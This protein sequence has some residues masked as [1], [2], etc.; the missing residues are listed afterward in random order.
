M[1]SW[2]ADFMKMKVWQMAFEVAIGIYD[3]TRPFP[4]EER[5]GLSSQMRRAAL[6][7]SSCIAE[8]YAR[9]RP[10][11]KAY[12]YTVAHSSAQELKSELLVAERLK[13]LSRPRFDTLMPRLDEIG[14]MLYG[15]IGAMEARLDNR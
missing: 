1:E 12:L 10:R 14:R 6:S 8:G 2:K 5:F 13:I 9:R 15:M 7:I 11:D 3:A 4:P